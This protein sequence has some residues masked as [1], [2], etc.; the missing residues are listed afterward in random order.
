L[1]V[2]NNAVIKSTT[3]G[4]G[5]SGDLTVT[6]NSI[7]LDGKGSN[8]FTG[9]TTQANQ[10]TGNGGDLKIKHTDSLEIKNNAR[11]SASTETSGE[12]GDVKITANTLFLNNALIT[13]ES[14]KNNLSNDN[15]AMSGNI[16]IIANKRFTLENDSAISVSTRQAKAGNIEIKGKGVLILSRNSEIRTSVADGKGEGGSITIKS[17][18]LALDTSNILASAA[19]GNGGDITITGLVFE[20]PGS[21]IDASSQVEMDGL[22]NLKPDTTISGSL[23]VLSSAFLDVSNQLGERCSARTASGNSFITKGSGNIAPAPGNLTP[24][25]LLDF[26]TDQQIPP[27]GSNSSEQLHSTQSAKRKNAA[28]ESDNEFQLA[29]KKIGCGKNNIHL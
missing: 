29:L 17:P 2:R 25:N 26:T 8:Q 1:E 24:S 20:S 14:K 10:G 4:S 23:S 3:S 19:E 16:T 7:I 22:V 12:A 9:L 6:A 13:S 28:S 27:Q 21:L 11:I 5:D 18:V 15:Q